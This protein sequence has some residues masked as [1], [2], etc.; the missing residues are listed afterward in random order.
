[1]T[2]LSGPMIPLLTIIG[3]QQCDSG[4]SCDEGFTCN[5]PFGCDDFI[6]VASI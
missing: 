1:M 4:A 2:I 3:A 6:I 5:V